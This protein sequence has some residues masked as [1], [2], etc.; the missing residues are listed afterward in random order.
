MAIYP[1]CVGSWTI[2]SKGQWFLMPSIFSDLTPVV[3][4][5]EAMAQINQERLPN[6]WLEKEWVFLSLETLV[7]GPSVFGPLCPSARRQLIISKLIGAEP[8]TLTVSSLDFFF[9]FSFS[10]S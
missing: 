9:F 7:P 1:H 6:L 10:G 4:L 2:R 3:S 8:E 5:E